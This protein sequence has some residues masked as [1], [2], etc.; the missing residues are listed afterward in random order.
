[1]NMFEKWLL[2][3]DKQFCRQS[4]KIAMVIDNC[5]AHPQKVTALKAIELVF[6]PPN[7]TSLTQPMDQGIIK[8][9]KVHYRKQVILRQLDAME[10]QTDIQITILDAM[11][12]LKRGWAQVAANTIS[13]CYRHAK[14]V[15]PDTPAESTITE[16]EQDYDDDIPLATLV[17][18]YKMQQADINTYMDIDLDIPVCAE[19]CES[20]I[21]E[22]LISA[23]NQTEIESE[24]IEEET[25]PTPSLREAISACETMRRYFECQDNSERELSMLCKM[26]NVLMKK[27]FV[28]RAAIQTSMAKFV[29]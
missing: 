17:D 9:L 3:L 23:R 1:M 19:S 22:D 25:T 27:D 12:F 26:H 29:N 4:R 28:R 20:D 13:N 21:L 16:T 11:T 5:P 14:F 8:N 10:T 6:L 24:V 18:M 7:T 15:V 2:K